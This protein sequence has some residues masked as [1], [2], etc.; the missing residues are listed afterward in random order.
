MMP[1]T[2][3]TFTGFPK[4]AIHFL[5]E[6]GRN[7]NKT[8][9]NRNKATYQ[10][11]IVA[12][13]LAFVPAL[14]GRLGAFTPTVIAEPRIGGSLFRIHRDTRFSAD[15]SPYKTHVGIRVR[16]RD[17]AGSSRCT[18]PVY[19]VEF[20]AD[21]LR[22]GVGV[23]HFDPPLLDAYR[24]SVSGHGGRVFTEALAVAEAAGDR[25]LGEV[26]ARTPSGFEGAAP[27]IRRKGFFVQRETRLPRQI[28]AGEFVDHCAGQLQPYA[29]LFAELR[30]LAIA[31]GK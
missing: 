22:L 19:Y 8:W 14:S 16:D 3:Q 4:D 25:L 27:L 28:H 15:K 12:P 23:K 24:Q 30:R 11:C 2:N 26:L 7:N 1:A 13:A 29:A 5:R 10:A 17:T 9:F 20:D 6:L 18:G 31:S 21:H